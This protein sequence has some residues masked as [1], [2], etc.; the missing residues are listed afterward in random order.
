MHFYSFNIKDYRAKTAH[1]SI[2]EHYIY[3]SLIDWYYLNEKS[4]PCDLPKIARLLMLPE[5]ELQNLQ[6]VLDEFFV[7]KK[8]KGD[9]CQS[10]HLPR[11]DKEIADYK[12]KNRKGNTKNTNA[13][14]K[15]T[16]GDTN[17]N[18]NHDDTN[19]SDWDKRKNIVQSLR[20]KGISA[21]TRM[22]MSELQTL[23]NAHCKND[24][25][26][27]TKNTNANTKSTNAIS[28][29]NKQEPITNNQKPIEREAS[30]A[31]IANAGDLQTTSLS[32]SGDDF[33]FKDS[34]SQSNQMSDKEY[35]QRMRIMVT[36]DSFGISFSDTMTTDQLIELEKS[37]FAKQAQPTTFAGPKDYPL[38]GTVSSELW[39]DF[40][41]T[42]FA[43]RNKQLTPTQCKNYVVRFKK[44]RQNGL[45]PEQ[46]LE[47]SVRN[48]YANVYEERA[49]PVDKPSQ[50]QSDDVVLST[51]VNPK[52]IDPSTMFS[53]GGFYRPC[54]EGYTPSQCEQ[55]VKDYREICETDLEAYERIY[56]KGVANCQKREVASPEFFEQ[57][58]SKIH[59]GLKKQLENAQERV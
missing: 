49:K 33:G 12:Y 3:R 39:A 30:I 7:V 54:F 4:L 1:L 53:V 15:S 29:P 46:A 31:K 8:L 21:N 18:T 51:F 41:D 57:M 40:C 26:S 22:K 43:A 17:T 10:Y 13:N 27:N 28:S 32:P 37:C 42:Y 34:S 23:L 44:M 9:P 50:Q 11:I 59:S 25:Q 47:Y 2:S 48:G 19:T 35:N 55:I 56:K 45:D 20:N 14:T 24:L 6:N 16:N 5:S 52:H 38:D 36:L 58:L